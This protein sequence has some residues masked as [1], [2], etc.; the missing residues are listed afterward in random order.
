MSVDEVVPAR[1]LGRLRA[2]L[3]EAR[4]SETDEV[5]PASLVRG[6]AE[7]VP[8][9]FCTFCELD[10]PARR[11]LNFQDAD[12]IRRTCEPDD[13]YWRLR[14]Q[15]PPC[16][17]LTTTGRLEVVQIS[18][19][20][21]SRQLRARQIYTEMFRPDGVEHVMCVPL[22]TA[23]GRTRVFLFGRGAGRGFAE[24]ERDLLILLQPHLHQLYRQAAGRR[25]PR[26]R[27]TPRQLDIV[28]CLALG[29]SNDEIARRLLITPGTVRKH[30]E[31]AYARLGVTSR[32]AAVHRV[33]NA[34]D[35]PMIGLDPGRPAAQLR[36][37]SGSGWGGP[38]DAV[39]PEY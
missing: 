7:L 25:G 37:P 9:V 6:L 16:H 38:I 33:F 2:L 31:N 8:G 3:D 36:R 11:Q 23:P 4:Q 20:V 15:H 12:G 18:D 24:S 10:L 5:P 1:L 19:F 39:Q 17:Y 32:T 13:P 28:R 29:M 27:L 35:H 34:A 14:H 26:S 22:P 30:L 21:T